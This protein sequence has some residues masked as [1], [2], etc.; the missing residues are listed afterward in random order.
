MFDS[1]WV[2]PPGKTLA[3][4]L[5]TNGLTKTD[6][7]DC[8]LLSD[9]DLSRLI[10]GA[11]PIDEELAARLEDLTGKSQSFWLSREE[12]YRKT[13]ETLAKSSM[14]EGY[15]ASDWLRSIPTNQMAKLGWIDKCISVSEKTEEALRFFGVSSIS[16]WHERYSSELSVAAFRASTT[17]D[18]DKAAT[19]AWLR[20]AEVQASQM[21]CSPWNKTSLQAKLPELKQLSMRKGPQ[22]FYHEL[23]AQCLAVGVC[24]VFVPSLKG[25]RA[26][27][28]CR[29]LSPN[30]ALIV[31]SNRYKTDDHFWF[32]F[33]HEV[34]H[35]VLHDK[36]GL[37]IDS[38]DMIT[39]REEDEANEFAEKLLIPEGALEYLVGKRITGRLVTQLAYRLGVSRGIVVGQLQH[40]G[41]IKRNSLNH[42][43][44]H[45]EDSSFATLNVF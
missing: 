20:K 16:E 31:L 40:K 41:I 43:K 45:F 17:Y 28:A 21:K 4:C 26:F 18:A 24:L 12:N 1:N 3:R 29:F 10:E 42:L 9:F 30:K 11:V 19:A 33:F 25:C 32:T 15:D 36:A 23:V 34:G 14:H 44:K 35:L 7:S 8:L 37:F 27:G 22:A 39:S 2:S 5:S 38:T 6:A 13:L